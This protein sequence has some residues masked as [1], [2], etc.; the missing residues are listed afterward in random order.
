MPII[1]NNLYLPSCGRQ[2]GYDT[3]FGADFFYWGALS[4][5]LADIYLARP[6]NQSRVDLIFWIR[7]RRRLILILLASETFHCSFIQLTRSTLPKL[8]PS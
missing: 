6:S 3:F 1:R 7:I 2:A 8:I 4:F 5:E